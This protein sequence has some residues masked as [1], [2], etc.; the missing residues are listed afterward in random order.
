[1]TIDISKIQLKEVSTKV[2]KPYKIVPPVKKEE[3]PPP[4]PKL[5]AIEILNLIKSYNPHI[6][7]MIGA[8]N[9]TSKGYVL[10]FD[11]GGKTIEI[12]S[13]GDNFNITGYNKKLIN[14]SKEDLADIIFN[15]RNN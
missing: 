15:M 2:N 10:E 4:Q 13:T 8:K 14:I 12:K 3:Q 9:I 1:M 11:I 6:M 5:R 7:R